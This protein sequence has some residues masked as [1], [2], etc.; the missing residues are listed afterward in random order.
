MGVVYRGTNI[1]SGEVFAVKTIAPELVRDANA[2]QRFVREIT[3]LRRL[4][5]PNIV[6]CELPFEGEDGALY[7]PMEL[8]DGDDLQQ[9]LQEA[10]PLSVLDAVA[11]LTQAAA[12]L[13]CLHA[14]GI[15]HRDVKLENFVLRPDGH[16]KLIDFGIARA[17]GHKR[18]TLSQQSVGTPVY[19]APELLIL[20]Q[21]ETYASD[22][23]ALG[24]MAF[25][26]LMGHG[27][28]ALPESDLPVAFAM[29]AK[30][31][32]DKG[33]PRVRSLQPQV[34]IWLD[35]L[36]AACLSTQPG[37]RPQNAGAVFDTLRQDHVPASRNPAPRTPA[38]RSTYIRP[39]GTP[40]P[41][42]GMEPEPALA[43]RSA[44]AGP[45]SSA[46]AL[47]V[48]STVDKTSARSASP[49]PA[50]STAN[51]PARAAPRSTQLNPP[52]A[53][54]PPAPLPKTK[55]WW[56]LAGAVVA[57]LGLGAFVRASDP[58]DSSGLR[59]PS[60]SAEAPAPVSEP[61]E[62]ARAVPPP[63]P[64]GMVAVP[65]GDFYM[66][67]N[68]AVDTECDADEKPGKTVHADGFFIDLTEVTVAAYKK[69]VDAEACSAKGLEMPVY[70][71]KDQ[72]KW[73]WACNWKK[74][75]RTKHP[76]NC[77]DWSQ[78][79]AYCKWAG[80]RLPTEKEWEKAARGTEGLKYPWG[81][82]GF[83]STKVA[84]IADEA[85]KK[86]YDGWTIAEGYDD[87][88][89]GTAPVG[90]FPAGKSPYGAHD[91]SGNVWEWVADRRTEGKYRSIRGG[92][93]R[94]EPG[95]ARASIRSGN[96]PASRF[97]GVGFRCA[98]SE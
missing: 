68:E 36:I 52:T 15:N 58:G 83:G 6:G 62:P 60:E 18:L 27:P 3:L 76:V 50:S 81:N 17:L 32:H 96:D 86:K 91:M 54:V 80:K 23:Y 88:Y 95:D 66:G 73:A 87:G 2:K 55:P 19:L 79:T 29:A 46:S 64:P 1:L 57:L 40:A 77:L 78:A 67:C 12:A 53:S 8:L 7:L 10:G 11:V 28:V 49:G 75:G 93:W 16:L 45:A 21:K 94:Y 90:S 34:P 65:A 97:N 74:S 72:P 71:G 84:N 22:V 63:P 26:L 92:S 41:S 30:A 42:L 39:P 89:V 51:E 82:S 9:R 98:Q 70:S 47:K 69:C 48:L 85:A 44:P 61:S 5:H 20:G 24:V 43:A 25:E 14:Q 38:S 35:S 13:G 56:A 4:D 59:E 37:D 33:L 31:A